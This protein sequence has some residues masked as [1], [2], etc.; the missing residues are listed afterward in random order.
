MKARR[1]PDNENVIIFFFLEILI[2]MASPFNWVAAQRASAA[3]NKGSGDTIAEMDFNKAVKR[4]FSE[5]HNLMDLKT[6]GSSDVFY[7]ASHSFNPSDNSIRQIANALSDCYSRET[8]LLFYNYEET[9]LMI[10]L[11]NHEGLKAYHRQEISQ[12]QL[13]EQINQ[14]RNALGIDQLQQN[15][16]PHRRGVVVTQTVKHSNL[17]QATSRLTRLLL[18][19]NISARLGTVKALIIVPVLSLGTVPFAILKPFKKTNEVLIDRMSICLAPSLFEIR[20]ADEA[21]W[22][23]DFSSP[24]IVGNPVY[25]DRAKKDWDIPALPGAE[26]E[27]KNIAEIIHAK[28]VL[29]GKDATK[30]AVLNQASDADLLYFATHGVSDYRNSRNNSFLILSG[31]A[32]DTGFWNMEEILQKRYKAKLAVLSACQTGLGETYR[33]G[34]MALGRTFQVAGVPRVVMSLWKVDDD[35][36]AYLMEAFV[37]NLK[38]SNPAVSLREAMLK[39][40]KKFTDP[41]KWAAFVLFGTPG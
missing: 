39:A 5:I 38:K 32:D 6:G 35:A 34:I 21:Q 25:T 10:W 9:T 29:V 40:R 4:H 15:R 22:S 7:K 37:F 11:L 8:A 31:S 33:G 26:K 18:P 17:L 13:E 30:A 28:S 14:L 23:M 27:A 1:D 41:S 2:Q 16:A 12:D 36:T 3:A 19:A 24:L 20:P